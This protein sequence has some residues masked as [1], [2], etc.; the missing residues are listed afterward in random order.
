VVPRILRCLGAPTLPGVVS[1]PPCG[2][3]R[4]AAWNLIGVRPGSGT[5]GFHGRAGI[6]RLGGGRDEPRLD[7]ESSASEKLGDPVPLLAEFLFR[8]RDPFAREG[9]KFESA[10]DLVAASRRPHGITEENAGGDSVASVGRH[11]HA[12]PGRSLRAANP[13][14]HMVESGRGGRG[15]RRGPS[16]LDDGGSALL[17]HGDELLLVPGPIDDL[18][19]ATAANLGVIEAGELGAR[20]VPE[21]GD[22]VD[23]GERRL[24]LVRERGDGT[25]VIEAHHGA[26]RARRE[27]GRVVR[28]DESVGVGGVADDEDADVAAR[29]AIK[30]PPLDGEN[31]RVYAQEVLAFHAR[32]A[33]ACTHEERELGVPERGFRLLGGDDVVEEREGAILE[34]HDD[35]LEGLSGLRDLEEL[36]DHGLFA[37][38]QVAGGKAEDEGVADV[39]GGAGD[40]DTNGFFHGAAKDFLILP[41]ICNCDAGARAIGT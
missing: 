17:D 27:R 36:E 15:G 32:G 38:Q 2:R 12:G 39:A 29:R 1:R 7:E 4:R 10:H 5:E 16:G 21:D 40:G 31:L 18:E 14:A 11:P 3:G 13:G 35:A 19:G 28:G 30:R 24:G 26:E 41:D 8:E 23:L 20:M 9:I 22:A 37:P 34:F 33:R 25:I 6:P